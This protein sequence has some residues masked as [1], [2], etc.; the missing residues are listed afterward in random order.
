[1]RRSAA[2]PPTAPK[3]GAAC[4]TTRRVLISKRWEPD[5]DGPVGQVGDQIVRNA[6]SCR[7]ATPDLL[8]RVKE[9]A[10]DG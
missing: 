6:S 4:V 7:A 10:R 5:P 8:T 3:V 2:L 9:K 1:M